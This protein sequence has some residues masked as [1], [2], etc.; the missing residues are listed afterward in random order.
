VWTP[1]LATAGGTPRPT[2][3]VELMVP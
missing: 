2:S 1:A 3:R